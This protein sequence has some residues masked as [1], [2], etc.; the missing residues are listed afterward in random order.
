MSAAVLLS[1]HRNGAGL[2]LGALGLGTL[3]ASM[4]SLI[5]IQAYSRSGVRMSALA[6]F[7]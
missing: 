4:A 1:L 6:Q 3:I 2:V 5:S 7:R